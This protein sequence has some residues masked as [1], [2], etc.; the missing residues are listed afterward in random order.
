MM[1]KVQFGV[2]KYYQISDAVSAYNK[3]FPQFLVRTE[4]VGFPCAGANPS[5]V[6]LTKTISLFA[7]FLKFPFLVFRDLT[8]QSIIINYTNFS[9]YTIP[10][11]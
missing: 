11:C 9:S 6:R 3:L 8:L 5:L 2:H 7:H 4:Q 10:A 1:V